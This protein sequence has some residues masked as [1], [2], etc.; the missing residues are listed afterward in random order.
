MLSISSRK[1]A[2]A[3]KL[4]AVAL[5]L[6]SMRQDGRVTKTCI[7][8]LLA[9]IPRRYSTPKSSARIYWPTYGSNT[10]SSSQGHSPSAGLVE[11]ELQVPAME[12]R[13]DMETGKTLVD[14][15]RTAVVM[16]VAAVED[17]V[18]T[19]P[20]QLLPRLPHRPH[21]ELPALLPERTTPLNTLSTMAVKIRM[22]LT[23]A[24]LRMS[25]ITSTTP[26]SKLELA[27]LLVQRLA[28]HQARPR[29]L[30]QPLMHLHHPQAR[31]PHHLQ[32]LDHHLPQDHRL[33]MATMRY[34][35][36]ATPRP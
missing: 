11:T 5:D 20:Q 31:P 22:R 17:M 23:V 2:A 36:P 26:P 18:D 3:C 19:I 16:V 21:L 13:A 29:A 15:T 7:C 6:W 33:E 28:R 4:R 24:M 25:H 30:L 34:S 14:T 1:R 27:V 9:R 35:I 12:V 32:G 10:R 8:T